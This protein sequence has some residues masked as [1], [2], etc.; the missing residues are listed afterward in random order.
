[1]NNVK[2]CM[3]AFSNFNR[4]MDG[5]KVRI[6]KTIA[7]AGYNVAVLAIKDESTKEYEILDGMEVYRTKGNYK[8][9]KFLKILLLAL[10]QK[11]VV[12]HAFDLKT[13]PLAYLVSKINNSKLIYDSRELNVESVGYRNL[14]NILK[15]IMKMIEGFLIK[16]TAGIIV[17]SKPI[18]DTLIKWY[19]TIK[20]T[21]VYNCP[22]YRK[23]SKTTV[24][25][26]ILGID[27]SK[28][29]VLYQGIISYGRGLENLIEASKY[30]NKNT[31]VVLIGD[32]I[33]KEK[34]MEYVNKK[35]LNNKVKFVN[36][37][38]YDELLN[39]TMSADIGVI[40]TQNICLN[41]YYSAP[42]KLFEYLMAGLPV[43]VSNFPEMKKIVEGYDVGVTFNPDDPKDIARAINTILSDDQMY[44]KMKKNAIKIAKKIFN[45]E[46]ESKK[47]L[48]LYGNAL[49]RGHVRCK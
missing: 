27:K 47:I 3:I 12:Y 5:S 30:M 40:P 31:V 1:V 29:I 16:H 23:Y 25:R 35:K 8:F 19:D 10:N 34:L 45:W 6:A 42:N 43:A 41:H 2:V 32:G 44:L 33:L 14:P 17:P 39:Y 7:N 24:L 20:P 38:P 49:G 18:A 46:K 26:D 21:V 9:T 4:S 11:P 22:P 15:F 13:L 36:A 28:R 37:V 48:R